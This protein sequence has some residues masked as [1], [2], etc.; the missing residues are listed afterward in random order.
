MK[1]KIVLFMIFITV[2]SG[3]THAACNEITIS[4]A[5]NWYPI[6]FDEPHS[7]ES[8]IAL[9]VLRKAFDE[10]GVSVILKGN[11][12][13]KRQLSMLTTGEIDA[14]AALHFNEDRNNNFKLSPAFYQS[15]VHI[16]KRITSPLDFSSLE[17]LVGY[18]GVASRGASFGDT[19]DNF[20]KKY[21]NILRINGTEHILKML[22]NSRVDYFISPLKLGYDLIKK[23]GLTGSIIVSGPPVD[24]KPIHTAFSRKFSCSDVVESFNRILRRPDTQEFI[25]K[26]ANQY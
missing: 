2:Y 22:T 25:R 12:P 17:D 6:T 19:F 8:G 14:I 1:A 4:Y 24:E 15:Q 13:W 26:I 3:N 7:K 5:N 11:F 18:T 10:L 16:F 9:K 20:S 23:A 21:L